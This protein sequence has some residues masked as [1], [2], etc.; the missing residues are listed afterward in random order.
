MAFYSFYV[1]TESEKHGHGSVVSAHSFRFLA[2]EAMFL[3]PD[4]LLPMV[5]TYQEVRADLSYLI[6]R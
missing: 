4:G 5:F 1:D 6:P 2:D 3:L